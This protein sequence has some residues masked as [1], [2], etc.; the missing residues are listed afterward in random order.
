MTVV[1]FMVRVF[2]SDHHWSTLTP[3][4]FECF[5]QTQSVSTW[6]AATAAAGRTIPFGITTNN[7]STCD[8][9][10][11]IIIIIWS[12][13]VEN[14]KLIWI[15]QSS[16]ALCP[17]SDDGSQPNKKASY[18]KW[19]LMELNYFITL[20]SFHNKWTV[21]NLTQYSNHSK[22][23]ANF[24]MT[25]YMKSFLNSLRTHLALLYILFS[26]RIALTNLYSRNFPQFRFNY[27]SKKYSKL[28][29]I[30]L[31]VSGDDQKDRLYKHINLFHRCSWKKLLC[32]ECLFY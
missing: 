30:F 4:T 27:T 1:Y 8:V 12:I 19:K 5:N 9:Q 15:K 13:R 23:Y 10:M 29:Y 21:T 7:S 18:V 2:H 3:A 14:Q 16:N 22:I 20:K 11:R 26:I 31:V 25:K 17:C 6:L 28:L 24:W 32:R